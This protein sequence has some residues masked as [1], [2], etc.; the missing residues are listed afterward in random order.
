MFLDFKQKNSAGLSKPQYQC[1]REHFGKK[2]TNKVIKLLEL[3]AKRFQSL[4]GNNII[5]RLKKI[6]K[7]A[8]EITMSITVI[9][10]S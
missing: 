6:W 4:S 3:W 7:E 2:N 10:L 5:E 1:P 9:S 8:E